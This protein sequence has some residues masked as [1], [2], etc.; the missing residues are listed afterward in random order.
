MKLVATEYVSLDG[1]MDEPGHWSIPFFSPE[2]GEF[3]FTELRAADALL[4]GR[5]TYEGFAKAWPTMTDTGEFGEKM[6]GMP[7]YV[8]S[9]TLSE[10]TWNAT[11][12]EGDVPEAVAKLKE[13][14]G[15]DLLLAGSCQI[16]DLLAGHDLIDEYRLMVHPIVLGDGKLRA[17]GST[18][19]KTLKLVKSE[20]F[21]SGIVLNTYH[22]ADG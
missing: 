9:R 5:K 11:L 19:R 3:K 4:L 17:F 16:L 1:F 10:L 14:P 6:N 7:K 21:S 20:T 8:A 12:I 18:P 13:Q 15:G 2:A 22:R